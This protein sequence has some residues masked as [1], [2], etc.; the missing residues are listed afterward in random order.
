MGR[1]IFETTL[2][3]LVA[4]LIKFQ[5]RIGSREKF[6]AFLSVTGHDLGHTGFNNRPGS[7]QEEAGKWPYYGLRCW[8]RLWKRSGRARESRGE[9]YRYQPDQSQASIPLFLSCFCSL[10]YH[11]L[12][13]LPT[14]PR[15]ATSSSARFSI[16]SA[17]TRT[18]PRFDVSLEKLTRALC[19]SYYRGGSFRVLFASVD[20]HGNSFS[21]FLPAYL[22]IFPSSFFSILP[23]RLPIYP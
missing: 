19:L 14:Y 2:P 8:W 17:F 16:L 4:A 3:L 20:S 18:P 21:L 12:T 10:F 13:Q 15:L 23:I 11:F 1:P 5:Q 22:S 9:G 6:G 7:E